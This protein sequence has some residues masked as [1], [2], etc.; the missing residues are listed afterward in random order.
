MNIL[1]YIREMY[2]NGYLAYILDIISLFAISCGV[3]VI[4]KN[5]P[6]VS[7]LFLIGLFGSISAYLILIGLG[8]IGLAYLVVYVGAI[9]I[10]FLFI[11]M[12]INIRTS[13]LQSNTRNAIPLAIIITIALN[14]SLFK[15]LPYDVAILSNNYYMNNIL[16]ELSNDKYYYTYFNNFA[17][18]TG[19]VDSI[20]SMVSSN[21]WDGNLAETGHIASIGSVMYTNYNMWLLIASFILL[22][23]MVG[24]L[25]IVFNPYASTSLKVSS[26][27]LKFIH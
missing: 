23:A 20:L 25:V 12:L 8:F 17:D 14:Y 15:L 1:F 21:M 24:V 5:N 19:D 4:V 16:Y 11:L 9:S 26:K 27:H 2:T 22:L 3:S 6:V 7:V 18:V 10:L 13:E